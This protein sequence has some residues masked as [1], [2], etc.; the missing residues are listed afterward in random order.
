MTGA[1]AGEPRR[2]PDPG[3]ASGRVTW[4]VDAES[5]LLVIVCRGGVTDDDLL[6]VIPG[7]WHERPEVISYDSVVDA[8]D[9]TSEGGWTWPVLREIARRWHAFARGRDMGRRTAI[10]TTD[11]WIARLASVIAIDYQGRRMRCF[12]CP[13][14]ALTWLGRP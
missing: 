6:A 9:L 7:I 13:Q 2:A 3:A 11:T 12:G 14:L 10:V 1:G 5:R 8:R 4:S